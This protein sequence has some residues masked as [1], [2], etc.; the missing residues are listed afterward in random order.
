MSIRFL[1]SKL[2]IEIHWLNNAPLLDRF[3][4]YRLDILFQKWL[5]MVFCQLW[6]STRPRCILQTGVFLHRNK[7]YRRSFCLRHP[8]CIS[9]KYPGHFGHIWVQQTASNSV[10]SLPAGHPIQS[11]TTLPW[12]VQTTG[13]WQPGNKQTWNSNSPRRRLDRT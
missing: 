11:G 3:A 5:V 7:S 1:L 4:C 6:G 2:L 13:Q 8:P 12:S 9:I 10:V